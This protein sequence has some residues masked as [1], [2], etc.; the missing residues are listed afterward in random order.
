M[1]E[2]ETSRPLRIA[3]IGARGVVGTYSG[4]E[5]YYEEVGSRL[6]ER[7]HA[8]TVYCR[9]YFTPDIPTHRGMRVRRL[10]S[11]R[12]KHLETLTQRFPENTEN[13]PARQTVP[14]R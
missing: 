6:A 9:S 8:V 12:S 1:V 11:I 5:T 3:F 7:G 10:P 2:T 14:T 13:S 4:I